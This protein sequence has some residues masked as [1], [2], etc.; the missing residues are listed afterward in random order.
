MYPKI[1]QSVNLLCRESA[2]HILSGQDEQQFGQIDIIDDTVFEL[3]LVIGYEGWTGSG[4]DLGTP[5]T[6]T[7]RFSK[8]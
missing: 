6:S 5:Q 2:I 8:Q 7:F 1:Y 3:D 4:G